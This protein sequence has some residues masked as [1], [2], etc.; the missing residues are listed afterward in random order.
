VGALC[1]VAVSF[2]ARGADSDI[3]VEPLVGDPDTAFH[4]EVPALYR[5]REIRDR[6]WFFMH[7]PGGADCDG[8]VTSR[9]GITPPKT[10]R[11]VFVDMPGV[12]VVSRG[13][14]DPA[15]WC[16]GTFRGHVEFRDWRPKRHRYVIRRIGN[17]TVSVQASQ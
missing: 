6:Y 13:N 15:P 17:F 7:G 14:V 2:P 5:I 12:R 11:R 10:A 4:I 1:A 9:V 3:E 16:A 8:A